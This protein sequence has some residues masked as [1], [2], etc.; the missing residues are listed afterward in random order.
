MGVSNKNETLFSI[1]Y[2]YSFSARELNF[3]KMERAYFAGLNFRD[4]AKKISLKHKNTVK[5]SL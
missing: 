1:T 5:N 3:V 2:C 4:L